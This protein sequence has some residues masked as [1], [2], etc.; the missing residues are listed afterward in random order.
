[1]CRWTMKHLDEMMKRNDVIMKLADE[2]IKRD[3]D[4]LNSS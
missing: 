1:M 3:D 4:D 2:T